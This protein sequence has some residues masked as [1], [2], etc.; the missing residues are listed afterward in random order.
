MNL[1]TKGKILTPEF[2]ARDCLETG[3]DLVGK[4]LVTKTGAGEKALRITQTEAYRGEEDTACHAHR[5]KTPRNEVLYMRPGTVYVYLCYGIHWLLNFIT[6]REGVPQ[7]VLI[8]AC[9]GYEGPGKLTKA[10]GITGAFNRAYLG[11]CPLYVIDDGLRREIMTLPR[12][13][14]DYASPEDRERLWRFVM[15]SPGLS[16]RSRGRSP[17]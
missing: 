10:L 4:L 1:S 5:G 16:G 6:A 12:V 11:E 3:P 9:E 17:R 2:F 14:I 7:G 13:G 8:R 15:K